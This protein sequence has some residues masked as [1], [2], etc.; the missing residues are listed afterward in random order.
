M[1]QW[2]EDKESKP[3]TAS[4]QML[5]GLVR[6]EIASYH[7]SWFSFSSRAIACTKYAQIARAAVS[8]STDDGV[9]HGEQPTFL[10][11]WN[12]M[13]Q[14]HP[15]MMLLALLL[16]GG[17]SS[18]LPAKVTDNQPPATQLQ[19]LGKCHGQR[20]PLV[21]SSQMPYA[22]AQVGA[23]TGYFVLDFGTT[24]S[25][26]DPN[27]FTG[28]PPQPVARTADKF[29]KFDFF[30]S[31]GTVTLKVQDHSKIKGTVRQAGIIGTDFLGLN[32]FTLDYAGGAVYRANEPSFCSDAILASE[33]FLPVS[34][35]GFY[36]ADLG[37]VRRGFP[38]VPT[39]PVRI[40]KA[41]AVAQLDT[42]F[43]DSVH[44]HSV[45][46][47]RAYF[48]ALQ[49][50]GVVL[51]PIQGRAT[52][53]ST[54]VNGVSERTTAYK[55]PPG[56]AFEIVGLDGRAVLAAPDAVLHL[57]ETPAAARLCG[58]ISTWSIPAAQ[59]GASFYVDAQRMV[60]DPY[61]S[62]VWFGGRR[63]S[64]RR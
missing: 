26:I 55:L 31:W 27:A 11:K 52:I 62:R 29:S 41:T 16:G 5:P 64:P 47:N 61:K 28:H 49:A 42:G 63:L 60:F 9:Y 40:G 13:M 6:A 10:E 38:R 58:G 59:V 12:S 15:A 48:K 39:V 32:A 57:K 50:A 51:L 17:T 43:A 2:F 35:D 18:S 34:T 56:K 21:I 54:C 37:K 24:A 25:T 23:A 1:G 45:N 4:K 20:R 30:G 53:L 14:V 3:A 7:R 44:R 36:S 8:K 33:G 46:I 22:L 19:P